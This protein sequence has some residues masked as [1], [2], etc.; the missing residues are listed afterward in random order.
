[1]ASQTT[2]FI[3]IC[4]VCKTETLQP[5]LKDS[6]E[7]TPM[8]SCCGS[9]RNMAYK[10]GHSELTEEGRGMPQAT[11]D[12]L[13]ANVSTTVLPDGRAMPVDTRKVDV[14]RSV[15][16]ELPPDTPFLLMEDVS[17]SLPRN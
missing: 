2:H 1:M 15:L 17:F 9:R 6:P 8:P 4:R 7:K 12:A 14:A 3:Y 13:Q 11:V 16:N 10:G 5:V